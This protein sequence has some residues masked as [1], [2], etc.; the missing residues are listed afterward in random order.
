MGSFGKGGGAAVGPLL[1]DRGG[2]GRLGSRQI[3]ADPPTH[4]RKN[5]MH[6]KEH[7][8]WRPIF[9]TQTFG[10]QPIPYGVGLMHDD[11]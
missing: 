7:E 5:E 10:L 8:K 2:G 9:R 3:P 11:D 1:K 4:I 6:I